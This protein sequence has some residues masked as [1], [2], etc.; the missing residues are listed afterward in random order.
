LHFCVQ[1]EGQYTVEQAV[2]AHPDISTSSGSRTIPDTNDSIR[3]AAVDLVNE[4]GVSHVTIP[5][6]SAAAGL[7]DGE[8]SQ[9]YASVD[10]VFL[11]IAGSLVSSHSERID[12]TMLRRRSLTESM[13]L[14]LYAFWDVVE[15]RVDEHRATKYMALAGLR[16]QTPGEESRS[17]YD[18][19]L[20][21]TENWLNEIER[22]HSITWELP[23]RQL[24][25]LMLATLD[26]LVLDYVVTRDSAGAH[27]LLEVLA[28]HLAQ[29]GR[30]VAK[31]YPH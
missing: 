10:A 27:K 28:Y 4:G 18:E 17:L 22:I 14:A 24:A 25:R 20:S 13:K 5:A 26:G 2:N 23:V 7:R 8:F 12:A 11:E 1:R 30:R 29:H 9:Y 31:N 19:F 6:I 15:K 16:T 21:S 3:R